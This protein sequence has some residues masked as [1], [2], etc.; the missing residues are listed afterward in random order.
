MKMKMLFDDA[1]LKGDGVWLVTIPPHQVLMLGQPKATLGMRSVLL[2]ENPAFNPSAATLQ[3]D[4]DS[5]QVLNQGTTAKAVVV[6]S[7]PVKTEVEM[8]ATP[9]QPQ[10]A[11]HQCGPG[12][13]EFLHL[14]EREL[15]GPVREAAEAILR[16]V[17][18]RYPGDL[19]RGLRLNFK[20]T[21]DNFWYVIVQPRAQ[22]L[23]ITVRG[24]PARFLPSTLEL[25]DDRPGYTRFTLKHPSEV[26][27]AF[28]VIERSKRR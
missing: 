13:R 4:I 24:S 23:S 15:R 5:I 20:N 18:A 25:K 3:V 16:T 7:K 22:G 1:N 17:R 10:D 11:P 28:R 19:Q 26:M 2:V 14:V 12:D 27:E 9:V 21:P 6:E 8:V